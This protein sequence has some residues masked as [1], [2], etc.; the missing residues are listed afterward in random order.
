[1]NITETPSPTLRPGS[2][3]LVADL[4]VGGGTTFLVGLCLLVPAQV[5]AVLAVPAVVCLAVGAGVALAGCLAFPFVRRPAAS[6]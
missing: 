4:L 6:L 3:G 2:R 1:M 5:L